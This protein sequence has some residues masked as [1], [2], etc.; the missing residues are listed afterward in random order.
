MRGCLVTVCNR[1]PSFQ[2]PLCTEKIGDKGT[3]IQSIHQGG[4]CGKMTRGERGA[5]LI[6]WGDIRAVFSVF[7]NYIITGGVRLMTDSF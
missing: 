5:I 6:I 1:A 3:R 4:K 7:F 2:K